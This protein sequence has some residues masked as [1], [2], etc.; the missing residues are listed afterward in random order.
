[1]KCIPTVPLPAFVLAAIFTIGLAHAQAASPA[2]PSAAANP[3]LAVATPYAITLQDGNSRVWERTVYEKSPAGQVVPKKQRYTEL[4]AGLNYKDGRGRWV[5]SRET[6]EAF[7]RGAVARQGP[8]QVIFAGNLNTAG[9][10]DLQTP[11]KKRLRSH[12]L[13]LAYHDS[14]SGQSVLIGQIQ[15]SPGELTASN[16]VL[17]PDAFA[18]VKADVRYTYRKSRFEQDV[19]LREQPPA[20]EA[21]GLNPETTELEVMTEFIDPPKETIKERKEQ[22]DQDLSWGR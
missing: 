8:Y 7:A 1:M 6:I 16:Q 5:E 12:I 2:L 20:P 9:A 4:A 17:Y 3:P 15:D 13:G 11:D 21:C 18:G 10:I 22:K 14:A 19:I